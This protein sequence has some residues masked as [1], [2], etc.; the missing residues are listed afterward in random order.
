MSI[1]NSIIIPAYN[2]EKTIAKIIEAAIQ[3]K[4]A[5]E[6]IVVNDGSTDS[7][8]EEIEKTGVDFIDL[9]ENS[10]K[11]KAMTEGIKKSRGDVL[12]FIDGDLIGL[13]PR[14][15]DDLFEPVVNGRVEMAIGIFDACL[16]HKSLYY[17]SGQRALTRNFL[18]TVPDFSQSGY[19]VEI[20]ITET[21]IKNNVKFEKVVLKELNH[22]LKSSKYQL[23]DG[24]SLETKALKEIFDSSL[25]IPRE[26]IISQYNRQQDKIKELGK[27]LDN[28]HYT[29]KSQLVLTP[30]KLRELVDSKTE[31]LKVLF[32]TGYNKHQENLEDLKHSL[33]AIRYTINEEVTSKTVKVKEELISQTQR[34]HEKVKLNN[35]K[36]KEEITSNTQRIKHEVTS[37]PKRIKEKIISGTQKIKEEM[38]S[39][40]KKIRNK[41]KEEVNTNKQKLRET[42][43]SGTKAYKEII[44]IILE[45]CS[46]QQK[47]IDEAVRE[48]MGK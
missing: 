47:K 27:S 9:K 10:G 43:T 22:T 29:F 11:G 38:D 15:I 6:I 19:G 40:T 16:V 25:E 14:H 44:V 20:L 7:T 5:D 34:F 35:Q 28:M 21:A 24:L 13:K 3:S 8:L 41:I 26:I 45:S 4:L 17:I 46:E 31:N 18:E 2:E 37:G 30:E 1:L 33:K 32:I 39:N 48:F 12:L 42:I 36:I 23:N